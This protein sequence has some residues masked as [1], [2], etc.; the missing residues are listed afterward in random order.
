MDAKTFHQTVDHLHVQL[1]NFHTKCRLLALEYDEHYYD[2][3][4]PAQMT[5][6]IRKRGFT[7][8]WRGMLD[9]LQAYST[10]ITTI[11]AV[12]KLFL[13]DPLT[14]G[15]VQRMNAEYLKSSKIVC[16]YA[17]NI[18]DHQKVT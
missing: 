5:Q 14:S 12:S 15:K 4:S 18:N 7:P 8:R 17:K 13:R 2:A 16:T 6:A 3:E 1:S 9:A 11:N 10:C